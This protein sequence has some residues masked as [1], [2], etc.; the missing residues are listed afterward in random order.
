MSS[1]KKGHTE[2]YFYLD[3]ITKMWHSNYWHQINKNWLTSRSD[4]PKLNLWG[5]PKFWVHKQSMT[6]LITWPLYCVWYVMV[7]WPVQPWTVQGWTVQGWTSKVG[8]S[9]VGLVK[10]FLNFPNFYNFEILQFPVEIRQIDLKPD[11]NRNRILKPEIRPE[12]DSA[13]FPVGS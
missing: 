6:Y 2:E 5:D 11:R 9:K 7:T 4:R 8:R 12:P 3:I 1:D 10:F 13:G